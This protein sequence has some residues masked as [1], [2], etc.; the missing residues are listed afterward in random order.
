MPP[1]P[2]V[3][4]NREE[5]P[6]TNAAAKQVEGELGKQVK[7]AVWKA[8]L[9]YIIPALIIIVVVSLIA[10]IIFIIIA[11][12]IG[13]GTAGKKAFSPPKPL[14]EQ[15]TLANANEPA[16]RNQAINTAAEGMISTVQQI[17]NRLGAGADPAVLAKVKALEM[18]LLSLTTNDPT[19]TVSVKDIENMINDLEKVLGSDY[20]NE[21][22]ALRK[23]LET[24]NNI[25]ITT[26]SPKLIISGKDKSYIETHQVDERI[27]QA[28]NYLVTPKELG[29]AGFRK[30]KVRRI[31]SEYDSANR[32]FSR[33]WEFSSDQDR[34]ISPHFSGQ[35]MDISGI[36]MVD[37]RLYKKGIVRTKIE[38]RPP[39]D[40]MVIRQSDVSGKGSGLASST[41]GAGT[42][43]GE[44]AQSQGI[45][46]L[47]N[48]LGEQTGYDFS[49]V[50]LKEGSSM[51]TIAKAMGLV[52]LQQEMGIDIN[53]N[54][55]N[56]TA[57]KLFGNIGKTYLA[58]YLN[59]PESGL[60]GND[61][62]EVQTN[63]GREIV[64]RRLGLAEGSLT[65]NT[66]QDI[67]YSVGK[68]KIESEFGIRLG[69]L[70]NL[71]GDFT[72]FVGQVLTEQ[73]LNLAGGSFAPNSISQI[74]QTIG[75]DKFDQIFANPDQVDAMLNLPSDQSYTSLLLAGQLSPFYYKRY[76]GQSLMTSKSSN[77]KNYSAVESY[78]SA[79][80]LFS[81]TSLQTGAA[82]Y[83]EQDAVWNI[84]EGSINRILQNDGDVFYTIGI[85]EVAKVLTKNDHEREVIKSWM[86][87]HKDLPLDNLGYI[88][89]S[90]LDETVIKTLDQ[91]K[92]PDQAKIAT[93]NQRLV[94]VERALTG[95]GKLS[96]ATIE[97]LQTEK[98]QLEER[99][100]IEGGDLSQWIYIDEDQ[101]NSEHGLPQDTIS[102]IFRQDQGNSVFYGIGTNKV[103]D[104]QDEQGAT[105]KDAIQSTRANKLNFSNSQKESIQKQIDAFLDKQ[106]K[107]DGSPET[108]EAIK[109]LKDNLRFWD[110][111]SRMAGVNLQTGANSS[112][113]DASKNADIKIGSK[114]VPG[115]LLNLSSLSR[116]IGASQVESALELPVGSLL[117]QI[118][119]GNGE[120][121]TATIGQAYIEQSLGMPSGSFAGSD[122]ATIIQRL[123][124]SDKLFGYFFPRNNT[125]EMVDN[126]PIRRDN[127]AWFKNIFK[128]ADSLFGIATNSTYNLMAG[129][130]TP[131]QYNQLVGDKHLK[132]TATQTITK[133]LDIEF[134]GYKL[135][136]QDIKNLLNGNYLDVALKVGAKNM[137]DGLNLPIG[138]VKA[139][140]AN[141]STSCRVEA[142]NQSCI[143]NLL[144]VNG[145]E[146]LAHF[147]GV[148]S[149]TSVSGNMTEAMGQ[150]EL[151]NA[152]NRLHPTPRLP[153]GW[154]SGDSPKGIAT[155]I[156]KLLHPASL[157]N[158]APYNSE[159]E[160]NFIQ[161]FGFNPNIYGSLEV[162]KNTQFI[163]NSDPYKIARAIDDE[164]RVP[165]GTT[166][167]FL[168]EELSTKDYK[169]TIQRA[170]VKTKGVDLLADQI[171]DEIK[172]KLKKFGLTPQDIVDGIN[173]PGSLYSKALFTAIS[174]K[175]MSLLTGLGVNIPI[176]G[177]FP[178]NFSQKLVEQML[179][180]APGSFSPDSS[181][182]QVMRVNGAKKF[183]AS[184]RLDLDYSLSDQ[185]VASAI[186]T[187]VFSA[188]ST[189]WSE[190][191][192][193]ARSR[194]IDGVLKIG[195]TGQDPTLL[196]LQQKMSIA[197]Y[198]SIVQKH[199]FERA[200][201]ADFLTNFSS[202]L[203]YGDQDSEQ[204]QKTKGYVAAAGLTYGIFQ[205][206]ESL[207]DPAT[208]LAVLNTLKKVGHV[209]VD[210]KL[211]FT[212]GTMERMILNPD[213]AK[214][215][216]MAQGM[217][218]LGA[219]LFF[220][221]LQGQKD[222]LLTLF[223]YYI[224]G[225]DPGYIVGPGDP[226]NPACAP[227]SDKLS[228]ADAKAFVKNHRT[229]CSNAI[230]NGILKTTIHDA[231]VV[232]DKNGNPIAGG[233]GIYLPDDDLD[234]LM[235]GDPRVVEAMGIAFTV[236][237]LKA[238][239]DE[240]GDSFQLIPPDFQLSYNDIK[241]VM[242]T[243]EGDKTKV[244]AQASLDYTKGYV[245]KNKSI[246][247][248]KLPDGSINPQY[249]SFVEGQKSA[250]TSEQAKIVPNARKDLQF[251][252][253]DA[254]MSATA[255]MNGLPPIPQGFS[256]VMMSGSEDERNGMLL[257]YGVNYVLVSK[258]LPGDL[259]DNAYITSALGDFVKSRDVGK[260]KDAFSAQNLTTA[261]QNTLFN[262]I[263]NKLS[264]KIG[265]ALPQDT[266]K[267]IYSYATTGN[268]QTKSFGKDFVQGQI[269]GLLDKQLGLPSGTSA[270]LYSNYKLFQAGKISQGDFILIAANIVFGKQLMQLDSALG[271]PPGSTSSIVGAVTAYNISGLGFSFYLAAAVA[272]Y[273]IL[274][275]FSKVEMQITC[276]GDYTFT[277]WCREDDSLYIQWSQANVRKMLSDILQIGDRTGNNGLI[278]T[279]MGTYRKEDADYFNGVDGKSADMVSKYFGKPGIMRGVKGLYQSDYMKDFVH[280]GY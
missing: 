113:K 106:S 179:G 144:A 175:E 252:Y 100:K 182:A 150:E 53:G 117:N 139:M 157:A 254:Q 278:P 177:D 28:L 248:P 209:D 250:I 82:V 5:A 253:M 149:Q 42:S 128:S 10:A 126:L 23:Q 22:A 176:K 43:F 33:E 270:T 246:P 154:F 120:M 81:G 38:A 125:K 146:Q 237:K 55:D 274:F 202:F 218:T 65:G 103:A 214:S 136:D 226:N 259:R 102:Q 231:T 261:A 75:A 107:G 32:R 20:K 219:N 77:F 41:A 189:Y 225:M 230:V 215:I 4:P 272:L 39:V 35:A 249:T 54:K 213:K 195:G 131:D 251:R 137:D 18:A 199:Q 227:A 169:D 123:G 72:V 116:Q 93:L 15:T 83:N 188:G 234:L 86:A 235:K 158:L 222:N 170:Y 62:L 193:L 141:P 26:S 212:P 245:D 140:I 180:L 91:I 191:A 156:A 194:N 196:L 36:D 163:E 232:K 90:V 269:G 172:Q 87:D 124:G 167:S 49:K 241:N 162:L 52:V 79:S 61:N 238:E 186:Q 94:A 56:S 164:L 271:L 45:A 57:D 78:S 127:D 224:P 119:S 60:K 203:V 14:T 110:G 70:D 64:A 118:A 51:A 221:D 279:V 159:G 115:M 247:Q 73:N 101:Y 105:S 44:L 7:K 187:N 114:D 210:D 97:Q 260:L 181:I 267:N 59:I 229:L 24:L 268:F 142:T 67:L 171:P 184:F 239:K 138:T 95:P 69:S 108:T 29:G 242:W 263:D 240:N 74:R 236:N 30:I 211:G 133:N 2:E 130:I 151:E 192:N 223:Q 9:P 173:D 276:V 13:N 121:G 185:Q 109:L 255:R 1:T 112:G 66:S 208:Q 88:Y 145:Q 132:D 92:N 8:L 183:G 3:G 37:R 27:L 19:N 178:E 71:S 273:T 233:D 58:K 129:N 168:R 265:I 190:P 96:Q 89:S 122:I 134:G 243:S 143:E 198:L 204:A 17:K 201:T 244:A 165:V 25:L 12:I 228:E 63:I 200:G 161:K 50:N 277:S 68:R 258:L 220:G 40:I 16:A 98:L 216:L 104:V 275:G 152:L 84:P 256:R 262:L 46:E 205:N 206:P 266:A 80:G 148:Y 85:D 111:E 217:R 153:N 155:N 257:A 147:M 99:L 11:N 31:K 48:L 197:D 34:S 6:A 47:F 280:I 21:I 76:V 166:A 207:R 135:N 264:E 160:R 174:P